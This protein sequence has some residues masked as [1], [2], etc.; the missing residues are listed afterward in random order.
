MQISSKEVEKLLRN[1]TFMSVSVAIVIIF[2]KVVAWFMTDSLSLLSSLV[3]SILDVAASIVSFIAVRYSLQPADEDHRFGHGK[4]EDIA[5]FSQSVFIAGS[6]VFIL[7]ESVAR[8]MNPEPVANEVVGICV[9]IAASVLT[10]VLL[11]YQKYVIAKTNSS[12]IKADS[13]H[14]KTDILVNFLVIVSFVSAMVFDADII[15]PILAL[16]VAFYIFKSAVA[17]GRHA[18][19]KLM[20]KEFSDEERS[21]IISCIKS[22]K[23]AKGFHDLK[24]RSSGVKPFIQFHLELDGKISLQDAHRI[25]DDIEMKILKFFPHAEILIHQDVEAGDSL[26]SAKGKGLM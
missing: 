9:M 13:L 22:N 19:D 2:M 21:Q 11:S 18:F 25:S 23:D 12:A 24:T 20:D 16:I 26:E 14:Y 8:L 1:A 5:A 15:D 4:A 17:V 6:G 3:D 10:L 7:I